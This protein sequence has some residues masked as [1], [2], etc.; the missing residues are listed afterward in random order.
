MFVQPTATATSAPA[1]ARRRARWSLS[2]TALGMAACLTVAFSSLREGYADRPRAGSSDIALYA[3]EVQRIAAGEGY[4]QA[5]AAE[6]PVRGY[7]TR[8]LFNWRTPLPMWLL[9][10]LPQPTWGRFALCGLAL[11]AALLGMGLLTRETSRDADAPHNEHRA[12]RSALLDLGLGAVWL[13]GALLPCALGD[14]YVMPDLWCSV[15]LAVAVFAHAHERFALSVVAGLGALLM[16]ELAL[17][18]LCVLALLDLLAGQRRRCLVWLGLFALF[19]IYYGLHAQQVAA[20]IPPD[21]FSHES[22]WLRGGGLPFWISLAQMNAL[23]LVLP[24]PVTAVFLPL[25][26]LGL[27]AWPSTA[28]RKVGL[29]TVAFL[30][31]FAFVGQSFNQYWG[32][33][34]APLLALG[35]ARAPRVLIDCWHTAEWSTH[36]AHNKLIAAAQANPG[37]TAAGR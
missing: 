6:L 34:I 14:L 19:A 11:C 30:L 18:G 21:A 10:K 31:A 33:L 12:A 2:L 23:L 29:V 9:G 36:A 28:G 15:C 7:P 32:V 26:L 27:T 8:S 1:D 35:L 17:P 25:A 4:Y 13:G 16:R 22:S 3:A 20:H 5:A 37:I 24:A